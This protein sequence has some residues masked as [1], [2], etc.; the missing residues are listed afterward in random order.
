MSKL[1]EAKGQLEEAASSIASLTTEKNAAEASKLKLEVENADLMG[2]GAEALA[3]G[4]ELALE[5][6]KCVLPDLD[7]SQFSIYHEVV[8]GKL[9]PPP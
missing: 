2:V 1:T 5:Q 3:D 4:F 9:I 6:I 8:D 7:L